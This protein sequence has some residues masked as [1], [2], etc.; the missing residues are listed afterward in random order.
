MQQ[1]AANWYNWYTITL[2]YL[3]HK[4]HVNILKEF[5]ALLREET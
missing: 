3:S 4:M 5:V 2:P 1:T